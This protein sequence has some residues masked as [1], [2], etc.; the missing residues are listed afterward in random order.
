[1]PINS[2]SI[3]RDCQLV[4]MGPF[5][6]VDLTYVTG[7]ESRQITQ[8]VRLDRLDGVPMGAELPKGWEGSFEVERGTSAV[9]DFIAATELAFFTQGS[10]PAGTVYQYIAEVDGSTSTF[11]YS[12]VVFKLV[13]SGSWKGD[14]SVKQKLEFFATQR[15][16]I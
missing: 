16:R 1:M 11:Q 14:T 10:L 7:F 13:N 3:G 12:G 9:D 4:V 2:F 15:Q 6:R 8:S 5:G